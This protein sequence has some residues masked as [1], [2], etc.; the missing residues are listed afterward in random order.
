MRKDPIYLVWHIQGTTSEGR[1]RIKQ[2]LQDTGSLDYI[3]EDVR[4]GGGTSEVMRHR[5]GDYFAKIRLLGD[6]RDYSGCLRL[7]LQR[8]PAA[9]RYW[10]DLMAHLLERIRRAAGDV[11]INLAFQGDEFPIEARV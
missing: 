11:V 5:L 2:T 4:Q 7:L 3:E 10:K 9:G 8:S 1:E 6:S